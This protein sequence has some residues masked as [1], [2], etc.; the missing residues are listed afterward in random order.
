MI[1]DFSDV[2][3]DLVN[4]LVFFDENAARHEFPDSEPMANLPV[5]TVDETPHATHAMLG[6]FQGPGY[7]RVVEKRE[8]NRVSPVTLHELESLSSE[9]VRP[10]TNLLPRVLV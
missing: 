7:L 8:S 9:R 1:A 6:N 3:G 10:P 5:N 4:Q 2:R